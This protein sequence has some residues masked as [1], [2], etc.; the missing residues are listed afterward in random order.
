MLLK[1][2][3]SSFKC[4]KELSA[5]EFKQASLKTA[6]FETGSGLWGE[7]TKDRVRI[8]TCSRQYLRDSFSYMAQMAQT[9]KSSF[10]GYCGPLLVE[11]WDSSCPVAA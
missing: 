3:L 8:M 11:N 4:F 7:E 2:F 5:Q 6:L 10:L 1:C 9:P